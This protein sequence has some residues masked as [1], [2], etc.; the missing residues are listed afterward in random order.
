[1]QGPDSIA[2]L[3]ANFWS[4]FSLLGRGTAGRVLDTRTRL[5]VEAPIDRPPYNAVL[6]FLD[7]GS[8]PLRR[9]VRDT[10]APFRKRAVPVV[11]AVHPTTSE[12]VVEALEAEGLAVAEKL[13]GMVADIT[14]LPPPP[15]VD[16]ADVFEAS[17]DTSDAWVDLVSWRY[18]LGHDTSRYLR[19]LYEIGIHGHSRLWM[20]RIDGEYVSKVV[21][22]I[23]DGVAGIYGVV[24]TE[25]GRGRGLASALTLSALNVAREE[26]VETSVLHSTPM[27]KGLYERLGYREVAPF[28]IWADPGTLHL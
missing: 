2:A 22:H 10:L 4:M 23:H 18:G 5:I 8:S 28:E 19:E 11:W 24:T 27:A 16:G 17:S 6:R 12:G 26:G 25:A 13:P 3:E 14:E 21:L 1:V 15:E 9:Q 20:A 7:D